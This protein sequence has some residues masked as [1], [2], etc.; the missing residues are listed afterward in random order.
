MFVGSISETSEMNLKLCFALCLQEEAMTRKLSSDLLEL[1][2]MKN[3]ADQLYK[4]VV[5][6]CVRRARNKFECACKCMNSHAW[7]R[8]CN[9][10]GGACRKRKKTENNRSRRWTCFQ[11]T[12]SNSRPKSQNKKLR[13]RLFF[14]RWDICVV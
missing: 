13:I 7:V 2:K 6:A 10:C 14:L 3:D 12:S 8:K 9:I 11:R 5:H 4:V 1:R